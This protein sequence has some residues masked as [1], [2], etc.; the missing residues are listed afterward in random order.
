MKMSMKISSYL[1][2]LVMGFGLSACGYTNHFLDEEEEDP[3]AP[4]TP[5]RILKD[6][7][8]SNYGNWTY[9]NLLTGETE[10]HP[11]AGEWIYSG[12]NS[13]RPEQEAEVIG[14]DWHIAV[15][16]YELRTN[17]ASVLNTGE[18]DLLAV[19]VLP[20]GDYETD[21]MVVYEEESEKEDGRLL[22]ADMSH[23]MDGNIGYMRCPF[24]NFVLCNGITRTATGSMPPYLYGTTGEV[25]ALRWS[26][27]LE[28]VLQITDTYSTDGD[29][30]Y[31]SFKYIIKKS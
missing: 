19:D 24:I 28:V 26:S 14:I 16:R 20:E 18:T 6:V 25:F 2:L 15:H 21:R 1:V 12:D 8:G 30:G 7:N 11:D 29:S 10:S 22:T 27:G 5:W 13:V 3:L 31:L 9:I 23:M 4:S 17:G